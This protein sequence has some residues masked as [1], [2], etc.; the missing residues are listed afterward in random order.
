MVVFARIEKGRNGLSVAL[1]RAAPGG[2]FTTPVDN[3]TS[4]DFF[5]KSAFSITFLLMF[6][7][8][9]PGPPLVTCTKR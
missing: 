6:R 4:A 1:A 7:P 8:F 3:P 2:G 9:S 5:G